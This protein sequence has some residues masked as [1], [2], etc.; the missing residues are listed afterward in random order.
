M[1]ARFTLIA[2]AMLCTLAGARAQEQSHTELIAQ[3]A[4]NRAHLDRIR[5]GYDIVHGGL[6]TVGRSKE[7][8]FLLH[9][10]FF[11]SL[12]KVNPRIGDHPWV[13][14]VLSML[15][16]TIRECGLLESNTVLL[17]AGQQSYARAVVRAIRRQCGFILSELAA[18]IANGKLG[19]LDG[20]RTARLSE[21]HALAGE[22]HAFCQ[23]FGRGLT[24]LTA[25]RSEGTKELKF[26]G[27][28]YGPGRE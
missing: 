19:M 11:R 21:L 10:G 8:E 5:R 17:T 12:K 4:A 9:D 25:S 16:S 14:D 3:I 6:Q 23:I 18:L 20:Q 15:E 28:V 24:L 1:I 27:T 26:I 2:V 13:K 22:T 7:G